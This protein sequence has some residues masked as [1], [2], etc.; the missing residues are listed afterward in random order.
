MRRRLGSIRFGR[1]DWVWFGS[2]WDGL[3]WLEMG[4]DG[5]WWFEMVWGR[6]GRRGGMGRMGR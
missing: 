6:Y 4:W 3:G 1:F 5:L 2:S